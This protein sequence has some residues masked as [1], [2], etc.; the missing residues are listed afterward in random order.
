MIIVHANAVVKEGMQQKFAE[1]AAYCVT[2]TNKEAGCI[3]YRLVNDCADSRLFTFVE[4]WE[5]QAALDAHMQTAHFKALG[6]AIK[7]L[8]DKPFNA[9]VFE[10]VKKG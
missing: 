6:P 3:S 5:T 8:L 2:E 10:A 9:D 1:A 4:E 7:D